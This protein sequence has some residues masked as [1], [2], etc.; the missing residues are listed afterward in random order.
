M[1]RPVVRRIAAL[2][3]ALAAL[4]ARADSLAL[5]GAEIGRDGSHVYVGSVVR[6]DP[7]SSWRGRVW[8]D[9]TRYE[10][11]SNGATVSARATGIEAALGIGGAAGD[12]WWAAYVGPRYERTELSPDDRANASRGRRLRAK[13][14]GET[15]HGIGGGWRLN[16]GAAYIISAEKYWLRGRIMQPLAPRS[17]YG[18]ELLRH[19]G[20]DYTATQMGGF[21]ALPICAGVSALIKGGARHD[22]NRGVSGYAGVEF[23]FPY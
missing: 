20:P 14:Q 15:E 3:A 10:Y 19:G 17:L 22:E 2:A 18:I 5:A 7:A 4:P 9:R 8:L 12:A 21:Y 16:A 11:D 6:P 23:S 1:M 13:L